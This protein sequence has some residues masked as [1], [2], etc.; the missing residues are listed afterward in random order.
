[1]KTT[2]IK[3]KK[4]Y[5]KAYVMEIPVVST[6]HLSKEDG[7]AVLKMRSEEPSLLAWNDSEW[8]TQIFNT[9]ERHQV[10][11]GEANS[12]TDVLIAFRKAGFSHVRFDHEVGD[13]YE[14]L[15][16]YEW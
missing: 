5:G 14:D 8:P 1:M 6:A 13:I 3:P 16:Q 7:A 9:I 15:K 12:L 2:D 11:E 4:T 10:D